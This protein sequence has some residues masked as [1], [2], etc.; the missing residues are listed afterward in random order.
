LQVRVVALT[1]TLGTVVVLALGQFVLI[2]VADG[3]VEQR[4]SFALVEAQ[5]QVARAQEAFDQAPSQ[6][7]VAEQQLVNDLL[8]RLEGGSGPEPLREIVLLRADDNERTVTLDEV[9]SNS[10]L[11]ST[12]TDELRAAVQADPT[13]LWSQQ[14]E[15][16]T[17]GGPGRTPAIAVGAT[18]T[19]PL[20]GEH[21]LYLVFRL[22]QEQRNLA[23]VQRALLFGQLVLVLLVGGIAWL[24][25]RLVVEP[26]REAAGTAQRLSAGALDERML[27]RGDDDLAMLSRS[28][29]AMADSLQRQIVQ[30]E[31]LS[32]LQQRFVSDVSHELRTP[33][34]TI[35]MAADLLHDKRHDFDADTARSVELLQGQIDRFEVLLADLLEV[36]R[37]DAG[38]AELDVE[39]VDVAALVRHASDMVS[40]L[41]VS[42]GVGLLVRAPVQPVMGQVDR[43]RVE[44]VVRNLVSNAV[45]HAEGTDVTVTL[46]WDAQAVAV[47]VRDH[48]I[49]LDPAELERVFDRF[50]RRD[51]ARART[52]GGTGL[53]LAISLEDARLHGG[54]ID[55]LG[56]AG[57]GAHFVLTVPRR[58]GAAPGPGPL[59]VL[60]ADRPGPAA[61]RHGGQPRAVAIG[62]PASI[63]HRPPTSC[64]PPRRSCPRPAPSSRCRRAP[65]PRPRTR[66]RS[67]RA[68]GHPRWSG[69]GP[70]GGPRSRRPPDAPCRPGPAASWGRCRRRCRPAGGAADRLRLHPHERPRRGGRGRQ[71]AGRP[72][73]AARRRG[74]PGR[75]GGRA[76]GGRGLPRR[77]GGA[78]RLLR[79]PGVPRPGR[80]VVAPGRADRGARRRRG[81][82]ATVRSSEGVAS[83]SV[84]VDVV[85][86][87]D[88]AGRYVEQA[89][90]PEELSFDLVQVGGE[91]RI[92]DLPAGVVVSQ[93]DA[94]RVLTPFEVY[95]LDPTERY[96]VPDVRWFPQLTSSATSLAR[97]LLGGP[98]APYL[99]ALGSAA[100]AGTRLDLPTVQ[101][102]D[103]VATVDLTDDGAPGQRGGPG[104]AARPAAGDPPCRAG[105]VV[106]GGE[107]RRLAAGPGERRGRRR[108][109]GPGRRPGRGGPAVRAR[110]APRPGAGRRRG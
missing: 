55:G 96:L 83:V 10:L 44:R 26:V 28:F 64:R 30:L 5:A 33:L 72:G 22:D 84:Q 92:A 69:E 93:V 95:F 62:H 70:P 36:S 11:P 1:L 61:G 107:R 46:A 19:L 63:P 101:V 51:P 34:T 82:R 87:I 100:P 32:Q 27:E 6:N 14:V 71:P 73:R 13:R 47:G 109:P 99:R 20:S 105:G 29:N 65:R 42:R 67:R 74:G 79:R 90:T 25:T 68:P 85:A 9:S 4:R 2:D 76:A 39:T 80:A 88:E 53:G 23:V 78:R 66:R 54:R 50:W 15:V 3:L 91:W 56:S 75:G 31:Q 41:A 49:G 59:A 43:R 18:V 52:S 21:E 98:S 24:V 77:G 57:A 8:P 108:H 40:G 12:I 7:A 81:V 37:F 97:A 86:R 60:P 102:V 58:S 103:G 16:Q 106:G 89:P 38:A 35:R 48:G 45:E 94:A 17:P 110:R 104:P